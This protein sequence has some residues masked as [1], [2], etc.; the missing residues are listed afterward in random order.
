MIDH[1]GNSYKTIV[2]NGIEWMAENLRLSTFSN[3]DPINHVID[4]SQWF[5]GTTPMYNWSGNNSDNDCTYGKVYNGYVIEDSRGI[6][7]SGW[8]IPTY[9]DFYNL[10]QYSEYEMPYDF[11]ETGS[12]HYPWP[13]SG[14]NTNESGLTILGT[15]SVYLGAGYANFFEPPSLYPQLWTSTYPLDD[16]DNPVD[17]HIYHFSFG[18]ADYGLYQSLK[19]T[20]HPIRLVK[21]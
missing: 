3:G 13:L 18:F 6:C 9:Q 2:I 14:H 4:S 20:G 1:E 8:H 17:T 21:D 11:I 12:I 16:F 7:P 10:W 19:K 15:T 5:N